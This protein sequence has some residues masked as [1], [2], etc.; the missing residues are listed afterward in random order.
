MDISELRDGDKVLVEALVVKV[1]DSGEG[2]TPIVMVSLANV[3]QVDGASRSFA[4]LNP[5]Q[6][7]AKLDSQAPPDTPEWP[8]GTLARELH[9]DG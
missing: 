7:H 3:T 5:D 1:A 2:A 6:I 9:H 4:T 8:L